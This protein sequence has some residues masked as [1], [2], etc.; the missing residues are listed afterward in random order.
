MTQ[1]LPILVILGQVGSH[2]YLTGLLFESG[3]SSFK[4]TYS[5]N[6][7]SLKM[8]KG[9]ELKW[10]T[11]NGFKIYLLFVYSQNVHSCESFLI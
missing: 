2:T 9:K 3:K 8:M 1:Q 7:G 4:N 10:L 6:K 5:K 11:L